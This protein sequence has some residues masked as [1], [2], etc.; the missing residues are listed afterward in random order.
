GLVRVQLGHLPPGDLC[1]PL[2]HRR[3]DQRL[4]VVP[5]LRGRCLRHRTHPTGRGPVRPVPHVSREAS[6]AARPAVAAPAL[7]SPGTAAF[8][9]GIWTHLPDRVTYRFTEARYLESI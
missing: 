8:P 7:R 4:H 6:P 5:R 2:G 9:G 3:R 1:R